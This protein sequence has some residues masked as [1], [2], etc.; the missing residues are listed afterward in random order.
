M[1]ILC[2]CGLMERLNDGKVIDMHPKLKGGVYTYPAEPGEKLSPFS[3]CLFALTK[4]S[5]NVQICDTYLC[6]RY[7]AKYV[8]GIDD[9]LQV[10]IK[11]L[12]QGKNVVLE[13]KHVPNQKISKNAYYTKK[14]VISR[15]KKGE[16]RKSHWN[17]GD[18]ISNYARTTGV[19][20]CRFC[21][22][23]CLYIRIQKWD[24]ICKAIYEALQ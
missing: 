13:G 6:A 15:Q 10:E 19:H 24:C 8:Q 11:S 23:S 5:T 3:P 22:Y 2:Q 18:V 20:Q 1:E 9:N 21:T 7:L 14:K 4:C 16:S 17:T 12:N